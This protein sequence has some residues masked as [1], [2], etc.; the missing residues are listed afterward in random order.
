MKDNR[1]PY[2]TTKQPDT[3]ELLRQAQYG[4]P[5]TT[6]RLLAR[7]RDTRPLDD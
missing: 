2:V 1:G 3:E 5:G 7:H 4:D 6:E